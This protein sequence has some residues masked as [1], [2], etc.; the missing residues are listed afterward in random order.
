[1]GKLHLIFGVVIVIVF[2]L[3]GQYMD[4]YLNHMAGAPDGLRML[5]RTRHIFILMAGLLNLGMGAYVILHQQFWRRIFQLIGSGLIVVASLL[6]I[7]AFFY[8]P[9]LADLHTPLS[10]WGTYLIMAGTLL[11]LFGGVGR[12]EDTPQ[13]DGGAGEHAFK[14]DHSA[15]E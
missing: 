8:E 11:H 6:F 12:V 10:H 3:T 14:C 5:Y 2:L 9:K 1:M 15:R 4:K 13:Q 7:A